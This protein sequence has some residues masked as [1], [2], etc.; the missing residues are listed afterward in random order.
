MEQQHDFSD[1]TPRADSDRK[2]APISM[3]QV[4]SALFKSK[5]KFDQKE[6]V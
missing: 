4:I 1:S 6:D 3:G 5:A 2:L